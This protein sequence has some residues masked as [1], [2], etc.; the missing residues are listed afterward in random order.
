MERLDEVGLIHD[1]KSKLAIGLPLTRL[2]R[3]YYLMFMATPE[4]I[5]EYLKKEKRNGRNK[6]IPRNA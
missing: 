2:Q 4:Q 1:I 6:K 3:N 5:K